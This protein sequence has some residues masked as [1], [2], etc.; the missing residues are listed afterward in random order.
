MISQCFSDFR[1]GR[2]NRDGG[3]ITRGPDRRT[4]RGDNKGPRREGGIIE[5]KLEEREPKE[6]REKSMPK[7]QAPTS[8]VSYK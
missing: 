3:N 8:V 5:V 7:Y 2:D 4:E 1:S 6:R